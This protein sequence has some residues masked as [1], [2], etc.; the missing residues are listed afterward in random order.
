[1][2]RTRLFARSAQLGAGEER[3][4]LAREIH[5]TLAPYKSTTPSRWNPHWICPRPTVSRR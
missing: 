4:R 5:D 1:M 2:E 3:S